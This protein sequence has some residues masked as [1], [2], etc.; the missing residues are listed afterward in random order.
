LEESITGNQKMKIKPAPLFISLLIFLIFS[1]M[2]GGFIDPHGSLAN[3]WPYG[4]IS[5]LVAVLS[6]FYTQLL[7]KMGY[8]SPALCGFIAFSFFNALFV[9][10]MT[11]GTASFL[12]Y[13]F[14]LIL[15]AMACLFLLPL[16]QIYHTRIPPWLDDIL[17]RL[18]IGPEPKRPEASQG[19]GRDS[20]VR[21]SLIGKAPAPLYRIFDWAI[22]AL[23]LTMG[24]F[25]RLHCYL[26]PNTSLWAD[27]A[28]VVVWFLND[29]FF[30]TLFELI[31][32]RPTGY[33]V[34]S[35]FLMKAYNMDWVI[36]LS[37]F[38]PS[39]ASLGIAYLLS[40]RIFQSRLA[41]LV[42]VWMISINPQLIFFGNEFKPYA[43]E[44]FL[45]L[46]TLYTSVKYVQ[47]RSMA[48]LGLV[49]A[50]CF[51]SIFLT[52]NIMFALPSFLIVLTMISL[53]ER[54]YDHLFVILLSALAFLIYLALI[55]GFLW[56]HIETGTRQTAQFYG[57]KYQTFY[58]G[59]DLLEQLGWYFQKTGELI[60]RSLEAKVFLFP[61][62]NLSPFLTG[63]YSLFYLAGLVV[64][65]LRKKYEYLLL[66]L[67][68]VLV[69]VSFNF[70]GLIPYGPDRVNL[71]LFAYFPL[72]ALLAVD[73]LY[74]MKSKA[75]KALFSI[76]ILFFFFGLQFPYQPDFFKY[77]LYWSSQTFTKQAIR[78]IHENRRKEPDQAICLSA[79]SIMAFN[80]YSRFARGYSEKYGQDLIRG[81]RIYEMWT[82]Q[83]QEIDR[84]MRD[85]FMKNKTVYVYLAKP[86]PNEEK[87]II[88]SL[89]RYSTNVRPYLLENPHPVEG[90]GEKIYYTES[91]LYRGQGREAQEK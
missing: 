72:P 42:A 88:D 2:A 66:F 65:A 38:I 14:T 78:Y 46:L 75:L 6:Y 76:G 87:S 74:S 63:I 12:V 25:L 33:M 39:G 70:L 29:G 79:E 90:L 35:F 86:L 48:S 61:S 51:L 32:N 82:K 73:S 47:E 27:E 85:I 20:D 36:K 24:C 15:S 23:I 18:K 10:G 57:N 19:K 34:F 81:F 1:A 21:P 64:Y 43:L 37:S 28:N 77:K 80:Y 7:R 11:R 60:Y 68:P 17:T 89:N 41:S 67:L 26:N 40:R 69:A 8:P 49:L 30:R 84:F 31:P 4:L 22:L 91:L 56:S 59:D 58:V 62:V 44:F 5:L 16:Y 13:P 9:Y 55:A 45:H 3:Q 50:S 53:R 52:L 71:Y 54:K 83:D